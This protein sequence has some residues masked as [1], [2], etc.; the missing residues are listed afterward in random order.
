MASPES[1]HEMQ[2]LEVLDRYGVLDTLPEVEFDR[3]TRFVKRLLNVP[4]VVINFVAGGRTWLKSGVGTTLREMSRESACCGE[5]IERGGPF[6]VADLRAHSRF[7]NDPM[8]QSWGARSYAGAPLTTPDGF[9]IGTLAVYDG[10]VR[11]FSPEEQ[12]F[13]LDL[14]AVVIDELELRLWVLQWKRA[15]ERSEYLAHHD[16]LTGLPNRLSLLDRT[17]QALH[18]AERHGTPVALMVLDLDR[19]KLINDSLGHAVGDELLRAV[20]ER[21][22]RM[23]RAEDTVARLGGDEFVVLLP[24]LGEPLG[25]AWVAQRLQYA[26]GEPFHVAG[27][28]LRVGCSLGISLYPTDGQDAEALLR[29]A[30]TAMYAAKVAGRGGYRFYVE[31]M[32]AAAQEKL[33]LRGRLAG[34]L[35]RG[36]FRLHYQPQVDLRT[37]RVLGA[38]ALVRWPQP[39]G[40][41]ITPDQFIPVAEESGM[42]LPLGEWVL[43]EACRQFARW[44]E[45]G[46]PDWTLAVNVSVRQWE[47]P[48]FLAQVTEVLRETGLPP[49]RLI[50]EVTESALLH[51]P[52]G[53]QGLARELADLG[54]RVALDDFGT[55]C[56]SLGQL[57]R[58]TIGQ[59]KLDRSFVG[60][61]SGW[62]RD[63]AI[64]RTV[65]TLGHWL[66]VPTVGEG[67]ETAEQLG[68]LRDLD[69]EVGQGFLLGSPLPPEE[70]ESRYL[71]PGGGPLALF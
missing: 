18:F 3:I 27:H 71:H 16:A 9:R 28:D 56:S 47:A 24:E 52:E 30:D 15:Q 57:Q 49:A 50:L 33:R 40:G 69:C 13:L 7:R 19:F 39:G 17:R 46:D 12:A 59:L 21:L 4:I 6:T 34:A 43:R 60:P 25:A 48:H 67:I 29:A 35:E 8:V 41:W 1:T 63:Q 53:T 62:P 68:V 2:R 11:E 10:Q 65:V 22:G 61:L 5:T 66:S 54:V 37:G 55:G 44:R 38:E 58:L 20:A 42:I 70:F 26:L 64:A 23:L 51:D 36:E 32:T 45:R 31:E 14:A